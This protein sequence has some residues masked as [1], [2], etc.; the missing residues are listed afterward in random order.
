MPREE[1]VALEI[2]VWV[3]AIEVRGVTVVVE[4]GAVGSSGCV[5]ALGAVGIEGHERERC[6]GELRGICTEQGCDLVFI[7]L[8]LEVLTVAAGLLH[9]ICLGYC[10]ADLVACG[11]VGDVGVF[12]LLGQ[13][14]YID[15]RIYVCEAVFQPFLHLEPLVR[16]RE[17]ADRPAFVL[18]P[19]GR[20]ITAVG[21][22]NRV[23]QPVDIQLSLC[24]RF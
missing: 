16:R 4:P 22:S 8:N 10:A 18:T 6:R 23:V 21:Q 17:T 2:N 20:C 1:V 19:L 24:P 13:G 3:A 5:A 12:P 9:R 11:Q 14:D 7:Y 15:E